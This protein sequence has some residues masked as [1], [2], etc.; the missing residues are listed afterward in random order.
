LWRAPLTSLIPER[1][2]AVDARALTCLPDGTLRILTIQDDAVV[3]GR[4][5]GDI[6]IGEATVSRVPAAPDLLGIWQGQQLLLQGGGQ[7]WLLDL[8]EGST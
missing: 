5:Q 3:I 2:G 4:I 6:V 8:A 7:V 1:K